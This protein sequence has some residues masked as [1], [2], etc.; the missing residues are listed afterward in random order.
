MV[1]PAKLL[2][3]VMLPIDTWVPGL[4]FGELV[5]LGAVVVGETVVGESVVGDARVGGFEVGEPVVG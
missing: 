4:A 5:L 2:P 3:Q 1:S